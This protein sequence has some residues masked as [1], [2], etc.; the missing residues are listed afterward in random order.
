RFLAPSIS[1]DL[2]CYPADLAPDRRALSRALKTGWAGSST[3]VY[4]QYVRS[5][6]NGVTLRLLTYNMYVVT[7]TGV[8][9][10]AMPVDSA[11]QAENSAQDLLNRREASSKPFSPQRAPVSTGLMDLRMPSRLRGAPVCAKLHEGAGASWAQSLSEWVFAQADEA[12]RSPMT[13]EEAAF[14]H[15]GSGRYDQTKK[16]GRTHQTKGD[17]LARLARPRS[18]TYKRSDRFD[19]GGAEILRTP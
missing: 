14:K 5:Y 4:V 17:D 8:T 6:N 12:T 15:I 3:T 1:L 7:K 19:V 16:S 18:Q 9:C 10:K 11:R 13:I 2:G